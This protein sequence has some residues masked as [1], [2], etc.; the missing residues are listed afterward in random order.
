MAAIRDA[1]EL[2]GTLSLGGQTRDKACPCLPAQP[3][4]YQL[5]STSG[6]GRAQRFHLLQICQLG[7]SESALLRRDIKSYRRNP[8][9]ETVELFSENALISVPRRDLP[10]C[11]YFHSRKTFDSLFS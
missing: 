1:I 11:P 6:R 4:F 9:R 7:Y 3:Y 8:A 5:A 10:L 2:H